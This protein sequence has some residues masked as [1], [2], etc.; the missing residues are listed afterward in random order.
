[1]AVRKSGVPDFAQFYF[2][3]PHVHTH[4][5]LQCPR[6][7]TTSKVLD[8]RHGAGGVSRKILVTLQAEAAIA[9][10]EG[11]TQHQ[12]VQGQEH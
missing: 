8:P 1:M 2:V 3:G 12:S 5:S 7:D 6:A 11:T 10:P 9:Q 4:V